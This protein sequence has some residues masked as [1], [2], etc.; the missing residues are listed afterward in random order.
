MDRKQIKKEARI[1]LKRNLFKTILVV[2][3]SNIIISGGYNYSTYIYDNTN[4]M[5]K[6]YTAI[7]SN[8]EAVKNIFSN[9]TPSKSEKGLIGPLVNNITE[10]KS[11]TVGFINTLNNLIFKQNLSK[12]IISLSSFIITLLF[13][14][15]VQNVVRV[16]RNRYLLE[17]RRYKT[18]INKLLFPYQVRK[19]RHIAYILF[20]KS[21]Y[22]LLWA[23]TI[24]GGIIKFYEYRMI[25]YILAEN[26]NIN[27]KEAFN[28]SK[29][30]MDGYKFEMFKMDLSLIGWYILQIMT[31]GVTSVLYFNPYKES[32]YAECYMYIRKEK[33]N[34]LTY[35]ELLNDKYLDVDKY[36]YEAYPKDGY[37]IPFNE[38]RKIFDI[39]Y[40]KDYSIT[41]YIL[42]FFTFAF[43][44]WFW[45]VIFC[46]T[47]SGDFIN[48]GT[49]YGPWLPIYGWGGLLI[50]IF[51][52]KFRDKP[53]LYFLMTILLCGLIEYSTACYLEILKG[54]RWWDYDGYFLNLHGRICLEGLLMFGLGGTGITYLLAPILNNIYSKIPYKKALIICIILVFSYSVDL[55]YTHYHPNTGYGVTSEI[56]K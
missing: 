44:G 43:I 35:K 4:I 5:H 29:E 12:S 48:R 21:L 30:M 55:A 10:N 42:L 40:N 33:Y 56:P 46:F 7:K 53:V 34:E 14:V 3:I 52:K 24:V 45:E 49:M 22:Q 17:Q 1:N 50:L 25:T 51:L 37:S 39:D 28:L 2:F 38:R 27:K 47:F 15:F 18:S 6:E 31:F 23:L 9:F 20:M 26:P 13:Y 16:G 8:Y 36:I 19:T 41:T 54:M 32:I 11:V